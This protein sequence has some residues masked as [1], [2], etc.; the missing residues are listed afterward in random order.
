MCKYCELRQ[1]CKIKAFVSDFESDVTINIS[2]CNYKKMVQNNKQATTAS[3]IFNT[4]QK[5][6]KEFFN[7][8][9]A[10]KEEEK[11]IK[12]T[13]A[14]CEGIDYFDEINVCCG[15]GVA[16]CGNCSTVDEGKVFCTKCWEGL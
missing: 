13:C 4:E 16:T 14:T 11:K 8:E 5:K 6:D 3:P 1:M 7:S 12:V 10:Y 9:L 15:C 2:N